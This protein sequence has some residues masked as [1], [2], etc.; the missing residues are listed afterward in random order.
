MRRAFTLIEM[1]VVVAIIAILASL[2]SPS[3]QR[4]LRTARSLSCLNN[5]KQLGVWGTT[6]ANDWNG[7]LPIHNDGTSGSYDFT[8]C[9]VKVM[10]DD[11][12]GVDGELKTGAG[13]AC[14]ALYAAHG[15]DQMKRAAY[16][17]YALN[18]H[19]GGGKV[20]NY[21]VPTIRLLSSKAF[22]FA[23]GRLFSRNPGLDVH[24]TLVLSS[25]SWFNADGW[26]DG[27]AWCWVRGGFEIDGTE[28]N[29]GRGHC[30]NLEMNAVFG[31]GHVAATPFIEYYSRTPAERNVFI[32]GY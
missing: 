30:G 6:Y 25:N 23:E 4:A 24:P 3:L 22:W 16:C 2:L 14:P 10:R 26:Q 17:A 20:A 9:W 13:M 18:S 31:D 11:G 1:L 19:M 7:V 15:G 32:R 5:L 21:N 28:T 27:G 12:V 8:K 29:P